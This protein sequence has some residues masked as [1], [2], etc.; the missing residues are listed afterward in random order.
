MGW[1]FIFL[2]GVRVVLASWRVS[3]ETENFE[4]LVHFGI[5][6]CV[7]VWGGWILIF[8]VSVRVVLPSWRVSTQTENFEFWAHFSIWGGGVRPQWPMVTIFEFF[9][10][11]EMGWGI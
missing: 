1:I 11:F 4:F 2:G 7:G 9:R 6:G 5:W 8:L 3:S 10:V